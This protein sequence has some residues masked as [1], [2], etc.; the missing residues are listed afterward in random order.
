YQWG[1][2][3]VPTRHIPSAPKHSHVEPLNSPQNVIQ[4]LS[5]DNLIFGLYHD[6]L[7]ILL[8][9]HHDPTHKYKWAL[10]GGWIRYDENLRYAAS[11]MLVELNGVK[12]VYIGKMKALGLV[13]HYN[14]DRV[15]TID[16][17]ILVSKE[18]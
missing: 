5:I 16:Y 18:D 15:M 17:Y 12:E 1:F 6:Q 10:P 4:A 2:I 9:K 8:I 7:K 3:I 13:D 14:T 11:L